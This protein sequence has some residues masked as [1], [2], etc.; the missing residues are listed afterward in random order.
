MMIGL[1]KPTIILNK[2]EQDL[3]L[4]LPSDLNAIEV[5]PFTD[6]I[7]IIKQ[8]KMSVGKL[9]A[10]PVISSPIESMNKLDPRIVDDLKIE[11]EKVTKEFAENMKKARLDSSPA[12]EEKIEISP[13]LNK[14]ITGL[15]ERLKDLSNLGL[16]TDAYTAFLR[17]NFYYNQDKYTE[18]L[19]SYNWSLELEPKSAAALINRGNA[20]HKLGKYEE[21]LADY[22]LSLKLMPDNA[23]TLYNR[24]ITYAR[25]GRYDEA[26][27]DFNLSLK[28]RPD[29]AD[30]FYNM[31]CTYSLMVRTSDA[32]NY[33]K[34][35]ISKDKKYIDMAKTDKDFDN[36]RNDPRF[37]KL[38]E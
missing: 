24:G 13:E 3:S 25:L 34:Q 33:L 38:I 7:D 5:I 23:G 35:A 36:I 31:A 2:R 14:R 22:N 30:T 1:G 12:K 29:N 32:I 21:A 37:Q 8:L 6:Y 9:L 10:S 20:Y 11:L 15:E 27:T 19:E 16:T 18:A 17:G 4:K 26:F 28:L